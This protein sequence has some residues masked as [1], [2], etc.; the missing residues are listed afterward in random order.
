ML[1]PFMILNDYTQIV[2]SDSD[3]SGKMK[4]FIETPDE[5]LGFKNAIYILPDNEWK[6]VIGYDSEELKYFKNL[7]VLN[8]HLIT[9]HKK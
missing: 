9:N 8:S 7:I 3:S 5:K 1:H 4:I 6:D 2:Y